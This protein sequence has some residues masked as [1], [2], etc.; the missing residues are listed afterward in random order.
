M[1]TL[2]SSSRQVFARRGSRSLCNFLAAAAL[3]LT[4]SCGGGAGMGG[5]SPSG[6]VLTGNTLVTVV[7]SS[8]ANDQ[9]TEFDLGIQSLILTNKTGKTVSLVSALQSTEFI[10]VNGGVEPLITISIPQDIYTSATATI[11]GA[12]FSCITLTPQGGVSSDTY[13]YGQTPSANVTVNVPAPITV[14]GNSMALS[15]NLLVAQSAEYGPCYPNGEIPT[16]SITPTFDLTPAA[17]SSQPTSPANGKGLGVNGQIS[18]VNTAG[19][20]FTL[21][22][23]EVETPRTISVSSASTTSYQGIN[24][25]SDLA[26]GTFVNLDAAIQSDG[27]LSATRIAVED[28]TATS[29]VTGPLVFVSDAEPALFMWGRQQQGAL[30]DDQF[31]LGSQAFSFTSA[32]FQISGQLSNVQELPFTPSFTASN[33]VPGQ[34]VYLSASTLQQSG[35][36]P[37]IPLSTVTLL[38]QSLDGTVAGSS[39]AGNFTVYTLELAS[40]DLFPVLAVQQGQASLL[41]NPSEVQVYVDASTQ[42]LNSQ[43]LASGGT[44][45]FYGLVFN[46]NGTLR[47]DC[48]QVND[49]VSV[50]PLAASAMDRTVRGQTKIV[51]AENL[52]QAHQTTQLITPSH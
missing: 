2:C 42:Q 1:N 9:L 36:F 31:V 3:C 38:P 10:H 45:R 41:T 43:P 4:A 20:S 44:F 47:M 16:Y 26:V 29:V 7:L 19:G 33:I 13:A 18:A 28:P 48:A 21:A 6:P 5:S 8:T 39:S 40:Y 51:R 23:P 25:F 14:T 11:G 12:Q 34:N 49:G 32:I 15:L 50:T 22:L 37:Y 27:S 35:G 17:F 24:N 46:D 52:G 30:Y